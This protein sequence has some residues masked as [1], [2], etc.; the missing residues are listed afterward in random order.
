MSLDIFSPHPPE[1]SG[2]HWW[3]FQTNNHILAKKFW[4]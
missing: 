3:H 2:L 4:T 1:Q